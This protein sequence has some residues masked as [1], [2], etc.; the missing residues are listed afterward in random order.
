LYHEIARRY[1]ARVMEASILLWVLAIGL[2]VTGLAGTVLPFLP[3]PPLML[4]GMFIAAWIDHFA[5]IGPW[6]LSILALLTLLAVI[7]DLV[8]AALGAR[9]VGASR[10]AVIG[11][12]VGTVVGIFFG[13]PGLI[14]GPFIGAVAGELLARQR[15]TRTEAQAAVNIG[16]GA[17]IGFV[18]GTVA[19]LA[20]AF[21]MAGVFIAAWYID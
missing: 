17:W 21:T 15:L 7:V 16:I 8:A 1:D 9:R 10:Q 4:L 19:K 3:G 13:L 5:R 6:T 14:L 2:M 20:V 18:I 12:G 11:A